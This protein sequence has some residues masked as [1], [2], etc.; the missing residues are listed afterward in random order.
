MV[1]KFDTDNVNQPQ[2]L[3]VPFKKKLEVELII[4]DNSFPNV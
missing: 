2:I 1:T 4:V 3:Y